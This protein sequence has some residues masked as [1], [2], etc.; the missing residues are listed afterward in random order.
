MQIL[1]VMSLVSASMI[2]DHAV[3]MVIAL[4]GDHGSLFILPFQ[5][6]G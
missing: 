6:E 4:P 5:L 1:K 2:L 3:H